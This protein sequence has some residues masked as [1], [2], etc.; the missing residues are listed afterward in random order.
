M[1]QHPFLPPGCFLNQKVHQIDDIGGAA[2][3]SVDRVS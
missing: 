2:Q 1:P 3:G